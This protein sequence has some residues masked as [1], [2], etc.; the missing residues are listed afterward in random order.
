MGRRTKGQND[1]GENGKLAM[2]DDGQDSEKYEIVNQ[3]EAKF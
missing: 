3:N 2:M 1:S